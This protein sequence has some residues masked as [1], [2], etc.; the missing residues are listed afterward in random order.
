[1][2]VSERTLEGVNVISLGGRFDAY[3]AN[4]IE[5]KLDLLLTAGQVHLVV[6]LSQL[7]YIS[8]SGLRVLL[9]ALKRA[10]KQQGDIK[11]ACLKPFIKEIFDIAGFTQLFN[12]FDTAEAAVNSFEGENR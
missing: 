10:R 11:L 4:D 7:D 2:E 8:S 9:T 1:M 5:R 12:M 6:E 3:A